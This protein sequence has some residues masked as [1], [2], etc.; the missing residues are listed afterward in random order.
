MHALA[1]LLLAS[2][3]AAC[4]VACQ[5]PA[6]HCQPAQS[7]AASPAS[8]TEPGAAAERPAPAAANVA[9][10]R[11]PSAGA[12]PE[13]IVRNVGLHIGGGP[14]DDASKAPFQ[15]ALEA[16]FDALRGCYRKIGEPGKTGVFGVDLSIPRDGG[17]PDVQ[18]PRTGLQGPKFRECVLAVFGNVEFEPPAR[19]PTVISYSVE[20]SLE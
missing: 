8:G 20:Y 11:A 9:G 14:N 15:R 19:G 18:N 17:K 12:L 16:H 5:A 13:V 10:D 4:A 3:C 1:R 2:S 6:C 7:P